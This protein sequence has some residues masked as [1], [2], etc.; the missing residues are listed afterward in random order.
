MDFENTKDNRSIVNFGTIPD[1]A[2]LHVRILGLNFK[3]E[4]NLDH[5]EIFLQPWPISDM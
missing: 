2:C 1:C 3:I 4:R 5:T